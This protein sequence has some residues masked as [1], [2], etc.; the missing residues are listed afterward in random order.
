MWLFMS[1][2]YEHPASLW[3]GHMAKNTK[4]QESAG[5]IGWGWMGRESSLKNANVKV[6]HL[7]RST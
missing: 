5:A 1:D 4:L 7:M 2:V 6:K 3:T